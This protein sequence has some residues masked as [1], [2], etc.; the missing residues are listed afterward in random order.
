MRSVAI[1]EGKIPLGDTSRKFGQAGIKSGGKNVLRIYSKKPAIGC[2]FR[3][4]IGGKKFL[5]E[6]V[7]WTKA[8]KDY[9]DIFLGF[10]F[11]IGYQLPGH[12]QNFHWRC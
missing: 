1:M 2:W 4:L 12:V 7:P 5:R 11:G 9:G 3:G 10:G 8:G 6:L